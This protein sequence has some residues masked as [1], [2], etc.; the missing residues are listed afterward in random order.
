MEMVLRSCCGITSLYGSHAVA[1][2]QSEITTMRW[3][4]S[5]CL[6]QWTEQGYRPIMLGHDGQYR[7]LGFIRLAMT[8]SNLLTM[9]KGGANGVVSPYPDAVVGQF[10]CRQLQ[11]WL[12]G[13]RS[14]C[15]M[16]AG[17]LHKVALSC[18]MRLRASRRGQRLTTGAD[19]SKRQTSLEGCNFS[20]NFIH[21]ALS[22]DI[23]HWSQAKQILVSVPCKAK[24]Q[25]AYIAYAD[26]HQAV[27]VFVDNTQSQCVCRWDS[28]SSRS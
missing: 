6:S 4:D 21:Q 19:I 11:V 5:G 23:I 8:S 7:E 26:F 28:R 22:H 13:L 18:D 10:V 16:A 25:L 17:L 12:A 15:M 1:P 14:R 24:Y 3:I 27:T 20:F 9:A 2:F